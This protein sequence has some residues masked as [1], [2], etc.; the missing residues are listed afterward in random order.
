MLA[1]RP[2]LM[3]VWNASTTMPRE[4][5]E[6][7]RT[8]FDEVINRVDCDAFSAHLTALEAQLADRI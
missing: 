2:H 1:L 6:F 4:R 3:S 8:L 7:L 5:K